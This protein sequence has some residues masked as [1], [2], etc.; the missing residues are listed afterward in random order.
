[1]PP[2]E[3]SVLLPA[4]NAASTVEV[5]VRSMLAQTFTDLELVA[6]DDGSTD[7][8]HALLERLAKT[9]SRVRVV[10]GAGRGLVAALHLGLR[11]CSGKWIAR[12]DADDEALPQRLAHS[13]RVLRADASL[14]GVGTQVEI[15][16]DDRPVSP[17]MQLY[18]AW[19]GS[20]GT[21]ELLHR[22]RFIESPL[23]HPSVTISR[24]AL[25]DVGAWED[26]PFPEDYQLWLKLLDGGHRLRCVQEVL[27]RWRDHD[28]RLTRTDPRYGPAAFVELKAQFLSQGP[29]RGGECVLWGAGKF[30]LG[31]MRALHARGVRT[32]RLVDVDPAKIGQRID[33]IRVESW[34]ALAGPDEGSHLL[35][36]VGAKGAR[37]AIRAALTARGFVEGRDFTCV[38]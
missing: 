28:A 5:A 17:N 11:A 24:A 29:L 1:M 13:L 19:L 15:F 8:T 14:C 27:L 26:G 7:G 23:C 37:E 34:E 12:M 30:G 6:I 35:C 16:R 10:M 38:A 33:G 25:E 18:A 4:R 9:D 22:E 31:L 21:P 36:A 2:P 20:L 3:V 32:R